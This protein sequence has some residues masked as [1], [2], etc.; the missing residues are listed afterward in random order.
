[1]DENLE[2]DIILI[3]SRFKKRQKIVAFAWNMFVRSVP[4]ARADCR[5]KEGF[6]H[7]LVVVCHILDRVDIKEHKFFIVEFLSQNWVDDVPPKVDRLILF[8]NMIGVSPTLFCQKIWVFFPIWVTQA[9]KDN[10]IE[11]QRL[12]LLESMGLNLEFL[13]VIPRADIECD[14]FFGAAQRSENFRNNVAVR[15]IVC[16]G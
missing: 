11:F 8:E 13:G 4:L 7:R 1:M 5:N 16:L 12:V 15:V 6:I 9:C 14:L 2:F 3:V 10:F